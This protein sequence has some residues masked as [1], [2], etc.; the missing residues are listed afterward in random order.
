MPARFRAVPSTQMALQIGALLFILGVVAVW[1]W[2][3]ALL[4]VIQALVALSLLFWG[5]IGMIIGYSERKAR[6]ECLAAMNDDK[7]AGAMS[8]KAAPDEPAQVSP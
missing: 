8:K 7:P 1:A 3:S 4:P 5:L 6:R 2:W